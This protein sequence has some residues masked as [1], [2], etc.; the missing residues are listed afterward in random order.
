MKT[1][2]LP[3]DLTIA[4]ARYYINCDKQYDILTHSNGQG[5][6]RTVIL[7]DYKWNKNADCDN[8]LAMARKYDFRCQA[9]SGTFWFSKGKNSYHTNG[10]LW[11]LA[12]VNKK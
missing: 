3:K 2:T 8:I 5:I 11:P 9:S 10:T 4:L 1:R 6:Q 12:E 7:S